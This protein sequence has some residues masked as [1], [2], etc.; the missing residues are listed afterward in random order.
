MPRI[1]NITQEKYVFM[2]SAIWAVGG[3]VITWLFLPDTTGLDLKELDKFHQCIV[4]DNLDDYHGEAI[5]PKHLSP[6]E[7]MFFKWQKKHRPREGF[8]EAAGSA[9]ESPL[10]ASDF[11][12]NVH[13]NYERILTR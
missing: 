9:S 8:S 12:T 13:T 3:M 2:I 10:V 5:N 7:R 6:F 11:D 1:V 4:S